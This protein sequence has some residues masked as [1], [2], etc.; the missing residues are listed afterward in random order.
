MFGGSG[1]FPLIKER[2]QSKGK[3]LRQRRRKT[4]HS[5]TPNHRPV[6]VVFDVFFFRF[7]CRIEAKKGSKPFFL[8][9][10]RLC[11]KGEA[12]R[13]RGR[14]TWHSLTPNQRPVVV[15]FVGE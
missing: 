2:L 3:A 8:G 11:S 9:G 12:L 14:K 7:C 15:V 6:V 13:Q 5:L 4:W 10:E 1:R